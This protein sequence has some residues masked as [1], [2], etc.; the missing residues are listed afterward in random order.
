[1]KITSELQQVIVEGEILAVQVGM[2]RT[3]VLAQTENGIRCGLAASLSNQDARNKKLF[4]VKDAG[5]LHTKGYRELAA[6]IDS[7]SQT[8]ASIGLATINALLPAEPLPFIEENASKY[9][10]EHCSGKTIALIG[11]FPFIED[12]RGNFQKLWVFELNP[13][14]DDLPAAL[15]PDYLPQADVVVL[16]ATTLVN[17]TFENLIPYCENATR[18]FMVGPSTPLSSVLFNYGLNTLSGTVVLK[19]EETLLGISQAGSMHALQ[20][21][22]YV[23]LVTTVK[24]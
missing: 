7:P 24:A 21:Q 17:H 23:K 1:M 16:T 8:E 13:R 20:E 6:M 10:V 5:K 18:V 3:A 19:P 9:L 12:L 11:H 14:D 15:A 2:W 22:G 4:S